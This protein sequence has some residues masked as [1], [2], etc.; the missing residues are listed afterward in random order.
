MKILIQ[1]RKIIRI[2]TKKQEYIV[3]IVIFKYLMKQDISKLKLTS[4]KVNKVSNRVTSLINIVTNK[5]IS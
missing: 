5:V 3:K 1:V 2:E 4:R